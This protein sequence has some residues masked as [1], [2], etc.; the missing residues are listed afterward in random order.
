[1]SLKPK[2]VYI[3]LKQYEGNGKYS[4]SKGFT[5]YGCSLIEVY[6]RIRK[7]FGEAEK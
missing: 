1:M 5:V 6:E 2:R 7:L 3:L 4:D